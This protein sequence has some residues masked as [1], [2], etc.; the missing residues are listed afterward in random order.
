VARTLEESVAMARMTAA[1]GTTDIVVTPH[2]NNRH[3]YEAVV[4]KKLVELRAIRVDPRKKWF[5]I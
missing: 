1:A 4:E 2:A 5:G 3:V